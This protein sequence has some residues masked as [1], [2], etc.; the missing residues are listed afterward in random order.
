FLGTRGVLGV[1]GRKGFALRDLDEKEKAEQDQAASHQRN[2][3]PGS[4][5]GIACHLRQAECAIKAEAAER[6]DEAA[7]PPGAGDSRLRAVPDR[8]GVPAFI[9]QGRPLSGWRRSARF[10]PG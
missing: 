7:Q 9:R 6:D 2:E 4:Y 3:E 5:T 8:C 1:L 10:P